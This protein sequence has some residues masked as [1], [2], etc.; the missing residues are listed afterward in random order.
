MGTK[1]CAP[2]GSKT[3]LNSK[4]ENIINKLNFIKR[5]PIGKGG[6]GRVNKNNN[7][8]YKYIF[9]YRFGKFNLSKI[10]KYLQ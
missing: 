2:T 4:E 8:F 1:C 3:E 9:K 7:F 5:Y 6:F 10:I